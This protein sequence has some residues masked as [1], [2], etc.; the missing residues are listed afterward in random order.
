MSS[1][2]RNHQGFCQITDRG[3]W[4]LCFLCT[5]FLTGCGIWDSYLHPDYQSTRAERLCHPYGNCSQ[6][7]WI[8]NEGIDPDVQEAKIQCQEEVDRLHGNGWWL[9]SVSK[10]LEV[11]DC[12]EKKGYVLRQ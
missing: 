2:P 12:M 11:G 8:A 6:G 7:A 3:Q 10:G 4:I 9:D 5:A 1:M